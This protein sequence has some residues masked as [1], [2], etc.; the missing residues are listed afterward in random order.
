[1]TYQPRNPRT[2]H[3][4]QAIV[5]AFRE[6]GPMSITRLRSVLGQ[7]TYPPTKW[8][9]HVQGIVKSME[10]HGELVAENASTPIFDGCFQLWHTGPNFPPP[11]DD[12]L[13]ALWALPHASHDG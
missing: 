5:A 8:R 3:F 7:V 2:E 13:E 10:R 6:H 9:G 12:D 4:H 1:M 11:A